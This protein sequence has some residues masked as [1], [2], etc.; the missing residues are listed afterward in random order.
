MQVCLITTG[1]LCHV[2]FVHQLLTN[3]RLDVYCNVGY[4]YISII[5]CY[6]PT[7]IAMAS[8][9]THTHSVPMGVLG[10]C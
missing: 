8:P 5:I 9:Y 7:Y 6:V 1:H 10:S 2:V 4:A 3:V